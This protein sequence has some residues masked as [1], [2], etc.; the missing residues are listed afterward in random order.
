MG[1]VEGAANRGCSEMTAVLSL[2]RCTMAP[3]HKGHS[4]RGIEHSLQQQTWPQDKKITADYKKNTKVCSKF[5]LMWKGSCL[6]HKFAELFH[7]HALLNIFISFKKYNKFTVLPT[8]NFFNPPETVIHNTN[9][10]RLPTCI[11]FVTSINPWLMGKEQW[12]EKYLIGS[13]V[14][15]CKVHIYLFAFKTT[16][17]VHVPVCRDISHIPS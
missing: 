14:N 4:L 15:A 3:R 11:T 9:K 6:Q 5:Q 1:S 17:E 2:I 8:S 13:L 10:T 16:Y 12:R 7:R